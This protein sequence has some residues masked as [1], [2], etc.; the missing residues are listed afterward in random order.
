MI[1][2]ARAAKVVSAF[3]ELGL[4]AA[5]EASGVVSLFDPAFPFADAMRSADSIHVH[6]RVDDVSAMPHDRI[7]SL[8]GQI[9]NQRDGYIKY[10]FEGG[11]NMIFSAIDV[12]QDDLLTSQPPRP[13]PHLDHVGIDLRRETDENRALFAGVP[14]RAAQLGYR[15]AAQGDAEKPVYCCHT[16]VQLKHWVYPPEGAAL[17]RPVEFAFGPLVIHAGKMGCDL[18]PI[19]P[20]H[21]LAAQAVCG[22]HGAAHPAEGGRAGG[23]YAPE[24]LARFGEVGRFAKPAWDKFLEYYQYA[25]ASEGALTRREKSLIGLAIAHSKQ[26]PYCIDAYTSNC[27]DSGASVEQMHEAVHV[28]AALSAGIDLAHVTQM[29]NALRIKGAID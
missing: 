1:Q 23:Y 8:E 20:A 3:E 22:A 21:P 6:G 2:H 5:R 14:A 11:I 9:E 27:L 29:H 10:A 28:A 15:H 19:D 13:R 4:L 16:S 18:R 7:R 24:D 25:T 17:D 12:A 26:C